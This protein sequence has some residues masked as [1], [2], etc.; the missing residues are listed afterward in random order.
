MSKSKSE[1]KDV[2]EHAPDR[3][4]LE[5]LTQKIPE[6]IAVSKIKK[7]RESKTDGLQA[8]WTAF[9][10]EYWKKFPWDLPFDE[11]PDPDAVPPPPPQTAD[12]AFT[13][14]GLNLTEEEATRKAKIQKDMKGKVKCWFSRQRPGRMGMHGNPYFAYLANLRRDET[15]GP[16]KRPSDYQFYM[17]HPDFKEAVD[18]RFE[19]ECGDDTKSRK[20]SVRCRIARELFE[21]GSEDMQKRIKK[22]CDDAHTENLEAYKDTEEGLPLV[23]PDVQRECRDNFLA[24]VQPLLAGLRA[25]TGLTL[26]IIGGCINEETKVFE[27]MSYGP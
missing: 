20:I 7:G 1:K 14:L 13:L 23:E 25:Y 4:C 16:P 9:F 6:Y 19:N 10:E 24:I 17:H 12:E 18:E 21:R 15:D 22:E 3:T 27:T 11:E 8:F 5:F 26:K 2:S